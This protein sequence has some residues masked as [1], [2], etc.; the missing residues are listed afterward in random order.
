MGSSLLRYK[1]Q[2]VLV[3]RDDATGKILQR[4]EIGPNIVTNSGDKYYAQRGAAETPTRTYSAG[5]MV[6]ANSFKR[7]ATKAATFG[8]FKLAGTYT[9]RQTFDAGYPKTNDSD[10][11]NT[12]RTVDAVTYKRTYTTAQANYTIKAVGISQLNATSAS[13]AGVR[14]LASYKTLSV[15]LQVTKTSSQTLTAYINHTFSGV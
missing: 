10:T 11:D 1:E 13:A 7:A 3:L 14:E 4:L 15:S 12:G 9:G 5:M 8:D 6:V 2:I